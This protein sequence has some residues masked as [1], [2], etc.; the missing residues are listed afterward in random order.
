MDDHIED[1]RAF[2]HQELDVSGTEAFRKTVEG[3]L[4]EGAGNNFLVSRFAA[5]NTMKLY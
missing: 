5:N 3:R 4:L 2:V 1:L